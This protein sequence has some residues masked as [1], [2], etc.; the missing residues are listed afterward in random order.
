[1]EK[2]RADFDE[3]NLID[4]FDGGVSSK[5]VF[6]VTNGSNGDRKDSTVEEQSALRL[7][8]SGMDRGEMESGKVTPPGTIIDEGSSI[9]IVCVLHSVGGDNNSLHR[10]DSPQNLDEVDRGVAEDVL[11]DAD[12]DHA[13]NRIQQS[14][15][16]S[17]NPARSGDVST[18]GKDQDTGS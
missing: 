14:M 8:G 1:M 7:N 9:V 5:K 11:E 15:N 2:Y 10:A 12:E 3:T 18:G 6:L 16:R 4:E 13:M 17:S